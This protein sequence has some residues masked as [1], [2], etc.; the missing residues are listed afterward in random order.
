M[1]SIRELNGCRIRTWKNRFT[2]IGDPAEYSFDNVTKR[3]MEGIRKVVNDGVS[4]VVEQRYSQTILDD[5]VD[6]RKAF[7]SNG[8]KGNQGYQNRI[9]TGT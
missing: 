2:R 1:F 8:G 3:T 7:R 4:K 9:G 5:A 6:F